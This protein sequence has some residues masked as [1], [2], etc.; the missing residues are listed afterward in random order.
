MILSMLLTMVLGFGV[1]TIATIALLNVAGLRVHD[2]REV[3]QQRESVVLAYTYNSQNAYKLRSSIGKL[4]RRLTW[5]ATVGVLYLVGCYALVG[6]GFFDG[7]QDAVDSQKM[8]STEH[9]GRIVFIITWAPV[10]GY[11]TVLLWVAGS[12][13]KRC[14]IVLKEVEHRRPRQA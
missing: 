13:S 7:V 5:A 10:T 8:D 9:L 12:I 4:P 1:I 2:L 14:Y 3:K 11:V 6:F